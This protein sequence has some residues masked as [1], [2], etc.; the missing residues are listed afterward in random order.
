MELARPVQ[1]DGGRVAELDHPHAVIVLDA[2]FVA[3][4]IQTLHV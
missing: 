1:L 4:E 2:V 3:L